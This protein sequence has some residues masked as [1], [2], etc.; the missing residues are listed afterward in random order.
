MDVLTANQIKELRTALEDERRRLGASVR[1]LTE[2]ERTLG[3]SQ[4][5]ETHAGGEQADVAS[6]L[7]EQTLDLSLQRAERERLAEVDAAL[8]KIEKGSFGLCERCGGPIGIDR[9]AVVPWARYCVRCAGKGVT[10]AR[11]A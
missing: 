11:T 7:T 4:G 3:E 10:G 2:G 8:E 6:D 9:L 5:D 1:W